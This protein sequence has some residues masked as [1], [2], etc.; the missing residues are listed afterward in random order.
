MNVLVV[1]LILLVLVIVVY[2]T[3]H[4]I[5]HFDYSI[6]FYIDLAYLCFASYYIPTQMFEYLQLS[7]IVLEAI[8]TIYDTKSQSSGILGFNSQQEVAYC[9][10]TG[11]NLSNYM[12]VIDGLTFYQTPLTETT[13][14]GNVSEGFLDAFKGL[15]S[16]ITNYIEKVQPQRVV[17]T[18][19]SLGGA[20]AVLCGV[21][22]IDYLP[23]TVI[24]FGCP[25][26]GNEA[27]SE[28]FNNSGITSVQIAVKDDVVPHL[29]FDL[30][31]DYA[32][33]KTTFILSQNSITKCEYD[34]PYVFPYN[35]LRWLDSH[36][37]DTYISLL[38][39]C[40]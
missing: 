35:P 38:K 31:Y 30:F 4:S 17:A 37:L 3:S 7:N 28:S 14:K 27:F 2:F 36:S 16:Q 6:Q 10:F 39:K 18:G 22:T 29:P 33:L 8:E 23:T 24:T 19:H 5:E 32:H 9:I 21:Y 13:I 40:K 25:K 11:T 34:K 15:H 26:V 12:T 20:I 1:T